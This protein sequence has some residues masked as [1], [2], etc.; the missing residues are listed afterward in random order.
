MPPQAIFRQLIQRAWRFGAGPFAM[1]KHPRWGGAKA[2]T[3]SASQGPDASI[4]SECGQLSLL[5]AASR[6]RSHRS[7]A[8]L[9]QIY[10]RRRSLQIHFRPCG[11][12][13]DGSRAK[14]SRMAWRTAGKV[15]GRMSK[16]RSDPYR[17]AVTPAA[18]PPS[19]QRALPRPIN[20]TP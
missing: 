8:L 4:I 20:D 5:R 16:I 13:F 10:S 11:H 9:W 7:L 18:R 1:C 15:G 6:Q 14:S 12:R 17:F 2:S 19:R 3:H